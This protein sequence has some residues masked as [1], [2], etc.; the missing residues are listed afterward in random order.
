MNTHADYLLPTGIIDSDNPSVIQHAE[1]ITRQC[2]T[3]EVDISIALYYVVRDSIIYN[4]YIA[5]HREDAYRASEIL[6][7]KSGHCVAKASLLCALGR[8]SGIPSRIGFATVRNHIATKQLIDTMGTNEFVYHGYT[9]FFLNDRWVIATPAFD[10]ETCKRHRVT[11]LEFNGYD[12]S[13]YQLYNQDNEYF[14]EYL[15]THGSYTDVPV[16]TIM[17]AFREKYGNT[18]VQQWIDAFESMRG[19]ARRKFDQEEILN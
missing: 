13:R 19:I 16:E 1:D 4:P 6:K 18:L 7:I 12:D 8:A 11:P 5:Y 15:Q 3:S 14:M 9:E 2:G 17:T 10:R